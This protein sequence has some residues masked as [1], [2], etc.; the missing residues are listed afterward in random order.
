[1]FKGAYKGNG[2]QRRPKLQ[3]FSRGD[4]LCQKNWLSNYNPVKD[5]A[6]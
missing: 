2:R 4:F 3:A 5:A 1:L 6:E